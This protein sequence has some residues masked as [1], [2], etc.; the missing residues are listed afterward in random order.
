MKK[1]GILHVR[2]N[3]MSTFACW[4]QKIEREWWPFGTQV[5]S[6]CLNQFFAWLN[7]KISQMSH[8]ESQTIQ[9]DSIWDILK[10]CCCWESYTKHSINQYALSISWDLREQLMRSQKSPPATSR[11]LI[12]LP[13]T[14]QCK[15]Q[16]QSKTDSKW[17]TGDQKLMLSLRWNNHWW[18]IYAF[19]QDVN[20]IEPPSRICTNKGNN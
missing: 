1:P 12:H 20:C 5:H 16:N 6:H 13:N 15:Y 7:M 19:Q 3:A 4:P 9:S 11:S 10:L 17:V 14:Y 8:Q 2:L 18:K